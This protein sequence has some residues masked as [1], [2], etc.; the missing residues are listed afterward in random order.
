MQKGQH[1]LMICW[2]PNLLDGKPKKT[3]KNTWES[4][5]FCGFFLNNFILCKFYA[6]WWMTFVW[7]C[8]GRTLHNGENDPHKRQSQLW[9][10]ITCQTSWQKIF[11]ENDWSYLCLAVVWQI[12]NM[13]KHLQ[14]QNCWKDTLTLDVLEKGQLI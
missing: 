14:N 12:L 3:S 10:Q 13:K 5:G 8:G 6:T 1:H 2:Q 4:F 9:D 11:C 7:S